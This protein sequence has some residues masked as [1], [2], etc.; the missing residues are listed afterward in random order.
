MGGLIWGSEQIDDWWLQFNPAEQNA[1]RH[2]MG[3]CMTSKLCGYSCAVS[4]WNNRE[5]G[6]EDWDSYTDSMN[7]FYGASGGNSDCFYH[8][9]GGLLNGGLWCWVPGEL[10]TVPCNHYP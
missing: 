1:F 10:Y 3:S 5:A 7:N 8:C 6:C 2:C 9:S 4:F